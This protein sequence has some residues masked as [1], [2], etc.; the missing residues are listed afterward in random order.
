MVIGVPREIKTEE[1]RVGMTPA[2]VRLLSREGHGVLVETGAGSGS[3]FS[4]TAYVEAGAQL[5]PTAQA[6]YAQSTLI[7]KVKEPQP[8]EYPF[9]R[10]D[11]LLFTF[12]HLAANE[13]LTRTLLD[14]GLSAFAYES[15]EDNGTLPLL[16]PMS[17]IAGR[18]SAIVGANLLAKNHG[19]S[20]VL[21]SGVSGVAR[22]NVVVLGSGTVGY[23]AARIASGMGADVTILGRNSSRLALI[24]AEADKNIT[25][26]F[27]NEA[28]I[29]ELLERA[30]LII[31]AVLQKDARTPRLITEAMIKRM[32]PGSVL[33]DVSID[34]GGCSETSRPTTHR[35][36]T[37][38]VH[39]VLHY[40]VANM[41]G[42]YAR[43]ATEALTNNTLPYVSRLAAEPFE[44][45][46]AD[47][48]SLR[49]A[50]NLSGGK[51]HNEAIARTFS[52]EATPL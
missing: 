12:L 11:H 1:Y 18:M 16:R 33:V 38:I 24:E 29:G 3:G 7:V 36:P 6:L 17:E 22:G 45:L 13:T 41:P 2:G 39:D 10:R 43:S 15:L 31:G 37:F 52:L 50:L 47:S 42:A 40:C 27:S 8:S 51:I 32:K 9:L 44:T 21:L 35:E 23:N 14:I 26:R 4:D 28:T 46:L 30:D 48:I 34:Q 19:G 49:S 5:V 25:T 20:G